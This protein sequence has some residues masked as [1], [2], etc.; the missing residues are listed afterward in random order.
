MVLCSKESAEV[1][2]VNSFGGYFKQY[3]VIVSP[4]K[5]IKYDLSL[6]DIYKSV[7]DNNQNVG[8]NVLVNN[9]EQ[10]I[11]RGI[12]LIKST[13]DLENIALKSSNGTPVFLKDVADIKIGQAVRQGASILNGTQECVGGIVMMLR[14]ENSRDVVK[15]VKEKI[16]EINKNNVL[17]KG[18]SIKPYYDRSG[19]VEA[20]VKT[21]A[22]ALLEGAILVLII[23]YL[24]LKSIRGSLVVLI[25]LPLAL[26]MTFAAMKILHIDANLMTL[27][28]LAISLGMIIDTTIIQVENV[29]RHLSKRS[30]QN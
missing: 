6:D 15:R 24:M 28:G 30:R 26:L 25:A 5:L 13:S 8:G 4:E 18:I 2:E 16:D 21:V 9:S 23:L 27:G 12:G 3:Q 17:P 7:E 11:V 29:Q 10:Y 20:S 14:G 1:N 19:I 22:S